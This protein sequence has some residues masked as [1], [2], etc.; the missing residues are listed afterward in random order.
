MQLVHGSYSGPKPQ[1][2]GT[3]YLPG[4]PLSMPL[5]FRMFLIGMLQARDSA[6]R[7]TNKRVHR[8]GNLNPA[9]NPTI[10]EGVNKV[11]YTQKYTL[12]LSFT[13]PVTHTHTHV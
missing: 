8:L 1:G 2:L 3:L 13:S 10:G 7:E 4:V 9:R 12:Y 11:C 6:C 5:T